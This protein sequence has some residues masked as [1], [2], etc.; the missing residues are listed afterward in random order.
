MNRVC[1]L[2]VVPMRAEPSDKSEL[3]SQILYG[4]T[5]SILELAHNI[6]KEVK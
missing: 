5:F 3:I 4:E 6:S 2:S 1:T